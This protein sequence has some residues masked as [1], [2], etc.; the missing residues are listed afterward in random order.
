MCKK[1]DFKIILFFNFFFHFDSVFLKYLCY[2]S[3]QNRCECDFG[4]VGANC[5]IQCQCN[6]HANCKG[7]DQLDICLECHNNTVG[8]QCDQCKPLYVGDARNNVG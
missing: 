5:S 7:P 6:G 3:L 4:Y 8:D 2:L 1:L